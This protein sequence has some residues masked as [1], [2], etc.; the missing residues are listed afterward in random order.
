MKIFVRVLVFA[1][2]V[3]GFGY[4]YRETL[5]LEAS[6]RD[7]AATVLR[8]LKHLDVEWD[9]QML[10]SK[11][12]LSS[13]YDPLTRPQIEALRLL[14]GTGGK[15]ASGDYRPGGADKKQRDALLSKVDLVERFKSQNAILRNSLRYAPLAA[16]EVK[17]KA[18]EVA[19]ANPAKRA[20]M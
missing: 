11:T 6:Q 12:G 14:E 5:G 10:R 19:E 15:L 7:H 13:N 1:A 18:R 4:L 17:A 2:L 8:D 16:Q 9:L 3:A 20:E